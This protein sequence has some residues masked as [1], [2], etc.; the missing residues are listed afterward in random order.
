MTVVATATS[1]RETARVTVLKPRRE[2]RTC[3]RGVARLR[4]QCTS[5][6]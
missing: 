5:C 4:V 6:E 2:S 3:Q 1:M